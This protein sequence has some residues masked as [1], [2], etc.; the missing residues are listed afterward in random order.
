MTVLPDYPLA[1]SGAPTLRMTRTR[2]SEVIN[3]KDWGALGDGSHDDSTA[4]NSAISFALSTSG[5]TIFFPAGTY[6]LGNPAT[7]IDVMPVANATY[8]LKLLG[9]G[10]D[11]TILRGTLSTG[12]HLV[13]FVLDFSGS[14]GYYMPSGALIVAS[15][16]AT[17]TTAAFKAGG[18]AIVRDM[19]V[20][21]D[22]TDITS[23]A[24]II[25]PPGDGWLVENCK[26]IGRS[27]CLFTS[28]FGGTIRSCI[29]QSNAYPVAA[30]ASVPDPIVAMSTFVWTAPFSQTTFFYAGSMGFAHSQ[31]H[32]SGCTATGFDCGY[33]VGDNA[34][35]VFGNK[36]Y[37]CGLG[38]SFNLGTG[39]LGLGGTCGPLIGCWADRCTSG[40][41]GAVGTWL[42]NVFSGAEGPY[43]PSVISGMAT[44]G[45]GTTVTVTTSV[46]HNITTGKKVLLSGNLSAW[47]PTGNTTGIVTATALTGTTF[48][49]PSTNSGA[50]TTGTWNYP[51]QY[52]MNVHGSDAA[53]YA[54]NVL[55][56]VCSE[57][58]IQW[59][60]DPS[61]NHE[62]NTV[63]MGM[64]G[65][66]GWR[67]V[68]RQSTLS[69]AFEMCTS[70]V[71]SDPDVPQAIFADLPPYGFETVQERVEGQQFWIT[72]APDPA[73]NPL[74]TT[75][76]A[77]GSSHKM[78]LRFDGTNWTRFA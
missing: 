65:P 69:W 39:G 31:G 20:Q 35:I 19:T 76:A 63:G 40:Q 42:A 33:G 3:V 41:D 64:H 15:N 54:A 78:G 32:I 29:A 26:F 2:L 59:A 34:N 21:N 72:D 50:A 28:G 44:S 11:A 49:F 60:N 18:S 52:C 57:V 67:S 58:S 77:G 13:G 6:Y 62:R 22:S 17:E 70:G 38:F 43:E 23:A 55:S 53:T 5:G 36:A 8:T 24:M 12:K 46:A 14:T 61:N 75:I 66:Y 7:P 1:A 37:R 47:F 10:R 73:T 48:S 27:G 56:A 4:I 25:G 51:V 71:G 30:S 9:A 68:Q 74:G 45:G 16:G